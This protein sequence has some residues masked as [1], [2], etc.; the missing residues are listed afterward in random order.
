VAAPSGADETYQTR[1]GRA[2]TLDLYRTRVT[3]AAVLL[4]GLGSG[5]LEV[6][7]AASPKAWLCQKNPSLTPIH[8]VREAPV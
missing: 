7:V 6:A 4:L 3:I 8:T 1:H 2:G 5:V